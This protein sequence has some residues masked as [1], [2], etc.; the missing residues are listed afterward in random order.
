LSAIC[1]WFSP[2][3]RRSIKSLVTGMRFPPFRVLRE[4]HN[5]PP[6]KVNRQKQWI[7]KNRTKGL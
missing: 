4:Y 1:V 2:S 7:C 3:L 5:T 6:K